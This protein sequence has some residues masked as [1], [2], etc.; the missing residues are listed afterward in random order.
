MCKKK[1]KATQCCFNF[2][3]SLLSKY[4]I[5]LF[6][7]LVSIP[8]TPWIWRCMSVIPEFREWR[9]GDEMFKLAY[10]KTLNANLGFRRLSQT[11]EQTNRV[12]SLFICHLTGNPHSFKKCSVLKP[13]CDVVCLTVYL[14]RFLPC[15]LCLSCIRL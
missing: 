7:P 14:Y 1:N 11:K 8:Q 15:I 9:Q 6:F 3:L 13:T 12:H 10:V 2:L 5:E 4:T